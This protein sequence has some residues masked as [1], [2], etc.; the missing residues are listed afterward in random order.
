MSDNVEKRF[1]TDI[2]IYIYIYLETQFVPRGKHFHLGYITQS[3]PYRKIVA[4]ISENNT[5]TQI[6]IYIYITYIYICVCV[7]VCVYVGCLNRRVLKI[8]VLGLWLHAV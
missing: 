7:C 2:Y 8:T 4:L 5:K 1:E 3:M 6:Y